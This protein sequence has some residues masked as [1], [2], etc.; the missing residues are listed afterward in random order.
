[1]EMNYRVNEQLVKD[2]KDEALRRQYNDWRRSKGLLA[3]D[4]AEDFI[5]KKIMSEKPM[6]PKI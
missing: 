5:A 6:A 4:F 2:V 1:M 3:V